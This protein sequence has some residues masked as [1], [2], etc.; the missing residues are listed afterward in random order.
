[1]NNSRV[2]FRL[3]VLGLTTGLLAAC[4]GSGYGGDGGS[5]GRATLSISINPGTITLGES[6]TI[7]WSSNGDNCTASGD[8]SGNKAG[9]GSESVT[10]GTAG[11]FTYNMVCSGGRYTE[12]QR[13][14]VTLT[15]DPVTTAGLWRGEV[16]CVE[17]KSVAVSGVMS[18]SNEL[19]FAG[20]GRHYVWKRGEEPVAF[21]TCADCLAGERLEDAP[22]LSRI[23]IEQSASS[24]ASIEG[25][26]TTQL[27]SGYTLTLTVDSA[28]EVIGSDSNGCQL[29]GRLTMR[30][31]SAKVPD[32]SLDV[33]G[34][35]RR[36]GR[37][38][39]Q[40]A[41]MANDSGQSPELFLS[42]SNADAA[43]GWR[44][45]R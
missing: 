45:V 22:V 11:E 6:A 27:S 43:I 28:G 25:S 10:P 31:P 21:A 44:L 8:W 1:M 4:G 36:D 5:L 37:Y 17:A 14:S 18:D 33:S 34:C 40:L 19:R 38:T 30:R 39:G 16:C 35:G 26:Y 32:V 3:S 41:L 12:S 42:A 15:V 20:L 7:T 13:G 24:T 2:A 29:N 9:D 23:A